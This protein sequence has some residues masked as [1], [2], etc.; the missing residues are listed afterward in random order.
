MINT[1]FRTAKEEKNAENESLIKAVP[2]LE[3][4]LRQAR[5]SLRRPGTPP[6][7]GITAL[8]GAGEEA[9]QQVYVTFASGQIYLV[10]A[11][12]PTEEKNAEAVERL[13]QLVDQTRSE[14][15]GLNVGITGEPVLD[16]DEMEQSTNDTNRCKPRVESSLR[17]ASG[18]PAHHMLT[19]APCEFHFTT[20]RLMD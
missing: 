10:T 3:R 4:I 13:R 8:F 12:A 11:Q 6:S 16:K 17:C 14:V 9:E 20:K 19:I 1:Q 15:P 5:D 18:A 2:A 7:P